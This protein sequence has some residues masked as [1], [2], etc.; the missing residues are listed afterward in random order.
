MDRQRF[1]PSTGKV[2]C[3][4]SQNAARLCQCNICV[5]VGFEVGTSRRKLK[6]SLIETSFNLGFLTFINC[7][8]FLGVHKSVS[9]D[10]I[11]GV[12]KSA[13]CGWLRS[14]RLMFNKFNSLT[15]CEIYHDLRN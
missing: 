1:S 13:N 5:L 2:S 4:P 12:H 3:Q 10:E 8:E 11:L 9:C 15:K 7:D 6:S 14:G